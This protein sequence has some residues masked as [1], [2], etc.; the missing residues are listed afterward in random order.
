MVATPIFFTDALASSIILAFV[1]FFMQNLQLSFT[2]Y[3]NADV[4]K[5]QKLASDCLLALALLNIPQ[6]ALSQASV[7]VDS[8]AQAPLKQVCDKLVGAMAF[9]LLA[10]LFLPVVWVAVARAMQSMKRSGGG[11]DSD[12]G[13]G[14]PLLH[15][16]DG[17]LAESSVQ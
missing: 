5:L 3:A 7:D 17:Q 15:E 12:R 2:P 9:F 11:R 13:L 14:E 10:P 8:E 16:D 4:N 6:R 1:A